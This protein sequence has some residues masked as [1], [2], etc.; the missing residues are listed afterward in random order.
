MIFTTCLDLRACMCVFLCAFCQL[1]SESE[2]RLL[3]LH[4]EAW[5]ERQERE[6]E[7]EKTG[8]KHFINHPMF[9]FLPTVTLLRSFLSLCIVALFLATVGFIAPLP[10]LRSLYLSLPLFC[11][12][13]FCVRPLVASLL[14]LS[15]NSLLAGVDLATLH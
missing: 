9:F 5:A 6:N 10:S 2:P 7:R 13:H 14:F 11:S 15:C 4:Q 12:Q 3:K 8:P 1:L